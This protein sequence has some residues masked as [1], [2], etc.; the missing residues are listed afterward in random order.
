[1]ALK[2]GE[3]GIKVG[4]GTFANVYKGKLRRSAHQQQARKGQRAVKVRLHPTKWLSSVAIKKIKAGEMKDGLDMTALREVKFLQ[5]LKHPN[6]IEVR[7]THERLKT[8]AGRL[9]QQAEH[10]SGS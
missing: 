7:I 9:F 1:M 3:K 2:A 4:E 10:Q 5:E 8:A 6:I